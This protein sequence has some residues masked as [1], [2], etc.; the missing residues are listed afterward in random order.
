MLNP[1]QKRILQSMKPEQKLET[2]LNLYNSTLE[3]KMAGLRSRY[4]DLNDEKI[5][6]MARE[7]LFYART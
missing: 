2:A 7:M 4:P 1:E 6:E 3:L 5:Q